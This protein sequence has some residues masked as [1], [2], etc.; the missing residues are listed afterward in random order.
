[1]RR[2][3]LRRAAFALLALLILLALPALYIHGWCRGGTGA[4]TA[5]S[6]SLPPAIADG[7]RAAAGYKRAE[8]RSFLTYPEWY[9][10][11]TSQDYAATLRAI[12]RAAS[13]IS[14][15][16]SPSGRAIATSTAT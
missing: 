9:I 6:A 16:P 3:W 1:M 14:P 10:V 8:A 4:E 2:R 5:T 7:L 13:A 12:A 11:F 15:R